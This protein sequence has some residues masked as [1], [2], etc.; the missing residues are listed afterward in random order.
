MKLYRNILLILFSFILYLSNS[1][2][3]IL[4][5]EDKFNNLILQN[6][7]FKYSYLESRNDIGVF[8]DFFY[9]KK[10]NKILIKRDK[11]N[12]PIVRFS[13]F[14]FKQIKHGDS[15]TKFNKLDLSKIDDKK[16]IELHKLSANVKLTVNNKEINLISKPYKLNDIK[17]AEFYLDYINTIDTTKGILEISFY[18]LFKNHRPD[19]QKYTEVLLDDNIYYPSEDVL[20][21]GWWP[22]TSINYNEYKTDVDIRQSGDLEFYYGKGKLFTLK[23]DSG[24]AQFR[25][26]FNFK[27]FSFDSQTLS[28][29]IIPEQKSSP[30]AEINWPK[31][32]AS[33]TFVT[34]E[35]GPFLSLINYQNKNMLKEIGWDIISTDIKS[36]VVIEE[37]YYDPFLEEIYPYMQNSINLSIEIKRNS[38]HYV[39]KIIIPVFLILCVAWSVLWIPTPKLDAR[40]TTS[41]VA[42]LALIAYNFVFEGDIPKLEYL[43]D[44]DKF[45]LLSY[46]FCCIPTFISIGF[47]RFILK[48]QKL[49]KKVTKI[50]SYIRRWG[51]LIYL[52][53]T[54]QI[55]YSV[56]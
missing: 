13:L 9:D 48:T 33:V 23:S 8:Y 11:K 53:I 39:F 46:I 15:V 55:F 34:P 20:I 32:N 44:L 27:N 31:G 5:Q 19:L 35:K 26:K 30:N 42:L 3:E 24:I 45:I 12:Y 18:S 54:F 41:I 28:I 16:I 37:N 2:A 56:N 14:N 25:Q 1:Y 50:N 38:A 22:V 36:N 51:A 17:L 43:T 10:Q 49:Q 4:Q 52:L 6:H 29:E 40:L 47:S 21:S 7:D